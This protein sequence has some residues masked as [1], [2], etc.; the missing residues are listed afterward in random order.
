M[1]SG[2]ALSGVIGRYFAPIT[3]WWTIKHLFSLAFFKRRYRRYIDVTTFSF[4]RY[5]VAGLPGRDHLAVPE[6]VEQQ[7]PDIARGDIEHF[8]DFARGHRL[9]VIREHI[10]DVLALGGNPDFGSVAVQRPAALVEAQRHLPFGN[11]AA[12]HFERRSTIVFTEQQHRVGT[13]EEGIGRCL[14]RIHGG[15]LAGAQQAGVGPGPLRMREF[16]GRLPLPRGRAVDG[17][18]GS[19]GAGFLVDLVPQ[20]WLLSGMVHFNGLQLVHRWVCVCV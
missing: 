10:E 20:L 17:D 12:A 9:V 5:P 4:R 11:I 14:E 2:V 19:L 7:L 8:G 13:G 3:L 16:E 6:H 15:G 18:V 1:L